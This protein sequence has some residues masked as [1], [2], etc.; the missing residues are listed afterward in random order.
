MKG[1]VETIVGMIPM[2]RRAGVAMEH[3]HQIGLQ[4]EAGN[5]QQHDPSSK[6]TDSFECIR[7]TEV[8]HC[9]DRLNGPPPFRLG[10]VSLDIYRGETLFL[11]GGNG[12]GKTS[13][14]KVLCGLYNPSQGTIHLDRTVLNEKTMQGYRQMFSAIFQDF[15]LLRCLP[16]L[17]EPEVAE[18]ALSYLREF[19]L[20]DKV[21]IGPD[22]FICGELSRGQQKRLALLVALIEGKP[23]CLLDEWAADQDPAFRR[24][25]YEVI[26]PR[27]KRQG[28]TIIAVTHDE[29]YYHIADRVIRLK[30]GLL[31][32]SNAHS[33]SIV[34]PGSVKNPPINLRR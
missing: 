22:E 8:V 23:I 10:P 15:T 18:R 24:Y 29:T 28:T 1:A 27:M 13:L 2:I 30:E 21:K 26:L 11:A 4:V 3:L 14:L 16:L 34:E 6:A 17:A 33:S 20:A 25:F 19:H 9:Y 5:E 31:A 12:V 7:L 32:S